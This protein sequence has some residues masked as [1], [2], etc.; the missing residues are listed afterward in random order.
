M[1]PPESDNK[2]DERQIAN[3]A[4][5][6]ERYKSMRER[7]LEFSKKP[8]IRNVAVV[9]S[10]T[11]AAQAIIFAFS[12][13]ITRLYGP[14]IFGV[15][16]VFLAMTAIVTPIASLTY[17][18]AIVLPPNDNDAKG[19]FFISLVTAGFLGILLTIILLLFKNQIVN[20]FKIGAISSFILLVPVVMFFSA[21]RQSLEQWLI[22]K[23]EFKDISKVTVSQA[24][25]ING[26]KVGAGFF[27][28][29]A[30]TLVVLSALKDFLHAIQLA[31][32]AL[33]SQVT[34]EGKSISRINRYSYFWKLAS[35]YR[36][37]P[38][39]R[40]P[41]VF[42][43]SISYSL[44]VLMFAS[45]FGPVAA[46][47]Y[48]LGHKV[49]TLPST[50]I[51]KSV[52]DVFFPRISEAANKNENIKRLIIRATMGLILAGIIPFAVVAIFGP[53]L[54]SFVFGAEWMI[55]GEYARWLAVWLFFMFINKPSIIAIPV[56]GIQ[57]FF[58]VY[59]ITVVF[60]RIVALLAGVLIFKNEIITL[61]LFSLVNALL[62]IFLILHVIFKS[63]KGECRC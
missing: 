43:N 31:F 24:F 45:F 62:Y 14:E 6:N 15:L 39:F 56:L 33:K 10:G 3:L 29:S 47:F 21:C 13:I 48:T 32:V 11:A 9:A 22:R 53:A 18:Q 23:K 60:I 61:A 34:K 12:P 1:P 28:P 49:L 27:F 16:G 26:T 51:S 35:Q 4:L 38:L 8:F 42:L 44:P 25:L 19:L 41:Q 37:F 57:G 52:G 59:E 7:I 17:A 5:E 55:A 63:G 54:F 20:L 58:L 40:S 2:Y 50:L 36:D 46:G 30:V